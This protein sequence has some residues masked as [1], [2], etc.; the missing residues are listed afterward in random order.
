MRYCCWFG[1]DCKTL[2]SGWSIQLSFGHRPNRT[3]YSPR[4]LRSTG[5]KP[6]RGQSN[7]RPKKKKTKKRKNAEQIAINQNC[8][9]RVCKTLVAVVIRRS[10]KGN[11]RGTSKAQ[12]ETYRPIKVSNSTYPSFWSSFVCHSVIYLSFLA[13]SPSHRN[14]L[15]FNA[16]IT[17]NLF[18]EEW[19]RRQRVMAMER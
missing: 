3:I 18:E 2:D 6:L 13:S 9:E 11:A 17:I 1:D 12:K 7:N 4:E 16:A 14:T 15:T 10:K 19:M 5:T 8:K